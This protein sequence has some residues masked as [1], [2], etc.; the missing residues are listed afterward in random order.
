MA[1][2]DEGRV[3][4][5][6]DD[7]GVRADGGVVD[8]AAVSCDVAD[9]AAVSC[10]VADVATVSCDVA[11]VTAAASA[12]RGTQLAGAGAAR[13]GGADTSTLPARHA[14]WPVGD[15][16]IGTGVA[17]IGVE[18]GAAGTRGENGEAAAGANGMTLGENGEAAV[19]A[20]GRALGENGDAPGRSC[21]C[22]DGE[23]D[24]DSDGDGENEGAE[25]CRVRP[26]K[27]TD[28]GGSGVLGMLTGV[29]GVLGVSAEAEDDGANSG[30]AAAVAV[31][32]SRPAAV[33]II[34]CV[35]RRDD[36]APVAV[37]AAP[38]EAVAGGRSADARKF[39]LC[40]RSGRARDVT[41]SRS[42]STV[43]TRCSANQGKL[44]A[45]SECRKLLLCAANAAVAALAVAA[46]SVLSAP[47][48]PGQRSAH[49][50][51]EKRAAPASS[52]AK[53]SRDRSR[54]W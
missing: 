11:D 7:G 51:A 49:V 18:G 48:L 8:V 34:T 47:R 19:G 24:D 9:V 26:V 28:V 39:N 6:G 10:V 16:D 46:S 32:E 54:F 33:I 27:A 29:A 13:P 21:W 4:R 5:D 52:A 45:L 17:L 25:A 14:A 12:D 40:S 23:G 15:N 42:R 53:A 38:D 41:E 2:G 20:N 1:L 37:V 31:V 36:W 43:A 30:V 44:A 22:G 50:A 3:T 35:A